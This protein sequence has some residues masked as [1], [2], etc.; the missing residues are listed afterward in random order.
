M[1]V[2]IYVM[3]DNS[4]QGDLESLCLDAVRDAP[5]MPCVDAYFG[6]LQ[7]IDHVP[8]QENKAKL[9]VFLASN[10]AD[11]TLLTGNA[12]AAGVIPWN[13][14]AFDGVHQFLDMLDA[15]N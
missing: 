11:P 3:P 7:T 13:S 12:I 15:V 1:R 14:P 2:I 5:A 8:T 9:R 6:C 4:S 10:L